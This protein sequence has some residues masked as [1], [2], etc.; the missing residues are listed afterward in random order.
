P[1]LAD[2][3]RPGRRAPG[4]HRER[5]P[6]RGRLPAPRPLRRL[7]GGVP[8]PWLRLRRRH[9]PLPARPRAGAAPAPGRDRRRRGLRRHRGRRM[10]V[11]RRIP[12]IVA[13]MIC[14]A[15]CT[16]PGRPTSVPA[17][18]A[19]AVQV[20]QVPLADRLP[21]GVRPVEVD[22]ELT[23]DPGRP[24][25]AGRIVHHLVLTEAT[26]TL[27]LHALDLDVDRV[28]IA[29][30]GRTWPGSAELVPVGERLAIRLG[31]RLGPGPAR[32]AIDFTG[33]LGS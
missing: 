22:L 24:S 4:R 21:D 30:A 25:F 16:P 20:D 3:G 9:R 1:G 6:A 26:D 12:R 31:R 28:K 8:R 15:G 23:I 17:G 10:I 11:W 19:P 27:W 18:G 2:P 32:L 33:R 29:A 13:L 14:L 7:P 5:L